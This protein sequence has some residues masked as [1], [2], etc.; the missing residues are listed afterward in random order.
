MIRSLLGLLVVIGVLL[1]GSIL[2]DGTPLPAPTPHVGP[3][4]PE[5]TPHDQRTALTGRVPAP[6]GTAVTLKAMDLEVGAFKDCGTST[7]R[8]GPDDSPD[9][10]SFQ[11]VLDGACLDGTEGVMLCW[12]ARSE[13]CY[14]VAAPLGM[15]PLLGVDPPSF[16]ELGETLNT[17]LLA[18]R[19]IGRGSPATSNAGHGP[20]GHGPDSALP[21]ADPADAGQQITASAAS[22]PGPGPDLGRDQQVAD[23]SQ[24]EQGGRYGWLLWAGAAMLVAGLAVAAGV[25]VR[26]RRS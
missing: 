9:T 5:P 19:V 10:S 24:S 18:P 15:R 20:D 4:L 1:P 3:P 8:A 2:A 13:D 25:G 26:A 14:I 11:F 16:A 17:G 23:L 22:G 6:S 7:T 21:L 12:S